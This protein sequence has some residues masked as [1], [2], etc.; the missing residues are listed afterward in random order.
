MNFYS[1]IN[2]KKWWISNNS[3]AH[4]LQQKNI[5]IIFFLFRAKNFFFHVKKEKKLL[6]VSNSI[7]GLLSA[8][9]RCIG[10]FIRLAL[11]TIHFNY[12]S[13][14]V[15]RRKSTHTYAILKRMCIGFHAIHT[16][17]QCIIFH[18]IQYTTLSFIVCTRMPGHT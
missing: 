16:H 13:T 7:M 3:I 12:R 8:A 4:L 10:A 6:T 18:F 9:Y 5:E 17:F 2:A 11:C 15:E 14:H 1:K